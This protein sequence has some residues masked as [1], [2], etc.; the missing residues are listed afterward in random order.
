LKSANYEAPYYA[1]SSDLLV[2]CV[3]LVIIF[4]LFLCSQKSILSSFLYVTDQCVVTL[5]CCRADCTR[6]QW[7]ILVN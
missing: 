3:L 4:P 6:T 1:V 5:Y 2:L 7:W